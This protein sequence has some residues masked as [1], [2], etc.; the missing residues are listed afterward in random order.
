MRR[1]IILLTALT[2]CGTITPLHASRVSMQVARQHAVEFMSPMARMSRGAVSAKAPTVDVEL[3]LSAT[4]GSYY[5]FNATNGKGYVIV[6]GSD[7]TPHVLGYSDDNQFLATAMPENLSAWLD[8]YS[9]QISLIETGGA[10][11]ARSSTNTVVERKTVSPLLKT[12]W[13]QIAPYNMQCPFG[14]IT[15]CTTTALAQVMK[16]YEHPKAVVNDIPKHSVYEVEKAGTPIDWEHMLAAYKYNGNEDQTSIDAVAHLMR[17]CG[18][19]MLT[20]WT[21]NGSSAT[22]AFFPIVLRNYFGYDYRAR[23]VYRSNFPTADD[24]DNL[25]YNEVAHGRP[26]LYSGQTT[27]DMGHAFVVDGYTG[28]GYFHVN[29]GWGG[30]SDGSFL[31]S[32]LAPPEIGVGGVAGQGYSERQN[33]TIGIQPTEADEIPTIMTINFLSPFDSANNSLL[34]SITTTRKRDG[35]FYFPTYFFFSQRASQYGCT[36]DFNIGLF[37]DGRLLALMLTTDMLK[38]T[39]YNRTM[40]GFTK[41]G[42]NTWRN[43][44]LGMSLSLGFSQAM[45][46]GEYQLHALSRS[47]GTEKWYRCYDD[48]QNYCTLTINGDQAVLAQGPY[49][50]SDEEWTDNPD[51]GIA[52]FAASRL[53]YKHAYTLGGQPAAGHMGGV[54]ILR[55]DDGQARKVVRPRR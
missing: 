10:L 51:M 42:S 7:L 35:C 53:P 34:E 22:D 1:N 31:L 41:S 25:I 24:W 13:D 12:R 38:E 46:D 43:P 40:E 2:L 33:A 44:G 37:Q 8:D 23:Q 9:V 6:S 47:A 19:S 36:I 3:A 16:Y 55:S 32:L 20:E 28:D 29:W 48:D 54:V 27:S 26:V 49:I 17:I 18:Q 52:P 4:D 14:T 21:L 15:G 50:L 30:V 5:V 39:F 11:P 45:P